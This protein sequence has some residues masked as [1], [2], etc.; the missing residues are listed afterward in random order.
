MAQKLE[1]A[2]L[3]I[4]T[5]HDGT[6]VVTMFSQRV[7]AIRQTEAEVLAHIAALNKALQGLAEEQARRRAL[8]ATLKSS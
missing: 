8:D 7:N 2:P 6:H 4:E 1:T 5:G 3:N